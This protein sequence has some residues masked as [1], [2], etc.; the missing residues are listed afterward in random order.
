MFLKFWKSNRTV[1]VQYFRANVF[2][3]QYREILSEA[4]DMMGVKV[5]L[6]VN[7]EIAELLHGEENHLIVSL[8]KIIGKQ[9]VIYP[10]SQL[11]MEEFDVLEI[12]KA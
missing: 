6:R 12:L 7:P 2:E 8:E 9:I 4:R 5:S 10:N 1:N 11:H 3:S